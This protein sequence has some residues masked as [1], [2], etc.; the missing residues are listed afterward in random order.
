MLALVSS[1]HSSFH[2]TIHASTIGTSG[3]DGLDQ[4]THSVAATPSLFAISQFHCTLRSKHPPDPKPKWRRWTPLK[5]HM[6]C[7]ADRGMDGER[8]A[9]IGGFWVDGG[10]K[11]GWRRFGEGG[12][13]R[14]GG[15]THSSSGLGLFCRGGGV[16][17]VLTP[18]P[19]LSSSPPL[20][21]THASIPCHPWASWWM[22]T[23][24]VVVPSPPRTKSPPPPPLPT[25]LPPSLTTVTSLWKLWSSGPTQGVTPGKS[26][27]AWLSKANRRHESVTHPW[28]FAFASQLIYCRYSLE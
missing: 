9:R 24:T 17:W 14:S 13:P 27:C 19:D 26:V 22:L 10:R 28:L 3:E 12:G 20:T 16:G 7:T 21:L 1:R 11:T 18:H 2:S 5:L 8:V 15:P 6:L 4:V 25:P 23:V